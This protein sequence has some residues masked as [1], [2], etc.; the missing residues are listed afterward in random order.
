MSGYT[1]PNSFNDLFARQKGALDFIKGESF[2][3]HVFFEAPSLSSALESLGG[4]RRCSAATHRVTPCTSTYFFRVSSNNSDL[5]PPAPTSVGEHQALCDAKK[6]LS[7]GF[8]IAAIQADLKKRNIPQ[9][10]IGMPPETKLP[11][12]LR[13]KPVALEFTEVYLDER[14]FMEHSGCR[15]YFDGYAVIMRAGSV[16]RPPTTIRV[17]TP[18]KNV[19]E[20]ILEPVLKEQA[21][22]LEPGNFVWRGAET[23]IHDNASHDS[24]VFLSLDLKASTKEWKPEE[25]FSSLCSTLVQFSHPLREDVI[26]VIAVLSRL[27]L[28]I[29]VETLSILQPIRGEAWVANRSTTELSVAL[30]EAGLEMVNVWDAEGKSEGSHCAGYILHASAMELK[31][32]DSFWV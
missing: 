18:T 31:G 29:L 7:V 10:L 19:V 1:A 2:L 27:S 11:D 8:P 16:N 22:P 5:C 3:L 32:V 30:R 17:G 23:H 26:R 21:C 13:E 28:P 4:L 25:E 6:K 14:A 24:N 12:H 9:E 15:E 20:K